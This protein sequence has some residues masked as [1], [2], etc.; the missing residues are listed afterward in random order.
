MSITGNLK[1]NV[2]EKSRVQDIILISGILAFSAA[3]VLGLFPDAN[4]EEGAEREYFIYLIMIIP[5]MAA[6]YF[7]FISFSRKLYSR[8]FDFSSSII[9]KTMLAFISVAILPSLTIIIISNHIINSAISNLITDDTI[10]S[11]EESIDLA[12]EHINNYYD[13]VDGELKSIKYFVR[14]GMINPGVESNRI[15]IAENCRLKGMGC[16]VFKVYEKNDESNKL[17][18][19]QK[20]NIKNYT[21]GITKFFQ[22]ADLDSIPKISHISIDKNPILLGQLYYNGFIIAVT[23][24]LPRT[25]Y[26]RTNLYKS[27]IQRYK[28]REFQK[29]YFETGIGV[30]LLSIA[31]I[32]VLI[33]VSV[34]F[35]LSRGFT[36]PVLELAE[37]AGHV[38]SGDFHIELKRDA[39]DELALLFKSFNKMVRQLDES[40]KLMFHAQRLEAWRDVARRIVHEIKNPLT[41]IRLSAER[42]QN[43]YREGNPDISNIIALGTETIIEE[44]KVL[45]RILNEFSGFA[46]LPEM[47]G[48]YRDINPVIENCV[49]FFMGHDEV[50]FHVSL[51]DSIPK[52]FIDKV[53]LRQALTNIIQ[54]SVDAL[55]RSGNIFVKSEYADKVHGI[56]KVSIRDDGPG[57]DEENLEKIFDP[58]FSTKITGTGL[59]LAI[60]EKIILEHNGRIFFH[61]VKGKGAEFVIELPVLE[62]INGKNITG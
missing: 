3:L 44:V 38:A 55:G 56:A 16:A 33:S 25:F 1:K 61:S 32:I 51:D 10:Y 60:V 11:L 57:I 36:K 41:P 23:K 2:I 17:N 26:S 9:F 37:A 7:I 13:S 19:L 4:I 22:N 50:S 39:T 28:N 20:E 24:D 21:G 58:T 46:R 59:G 62:D 45:N 34:S 40:K 52:L 15:H 31:I 35:F 29:P 12:N 42:I 48:E 54:N 30:L 43:R 27:S 5:M 53:L 14:K 6:I 18:I 49:N 47:R 8:S